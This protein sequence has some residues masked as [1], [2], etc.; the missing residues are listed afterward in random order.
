VSTQVFG[1]LTPL[2]SVDGLKGR[3]KVLCRCS[4]GNEKS[5]YVHNLRGGRTQSC[6][7]LQLE[8]VTSHGESYTRLYRC[9]EHMI[10]RCYVEKD[11]AYVYYGGRGIRVCEEWRLDYVSFRNWAIKNGYEGHLTIDRIDNDGC[12]C[13]ENCRWAPQSEQVRNRRKDTKASSRYKGVS[14]DKQ[15]RKWR[16]QIQI[17]GKNIYLGRFETEED[18]S[19]AYQIALKKCNS[20]F[21]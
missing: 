12:Y 13:P 16:S 5:I 20:I 17:D 10:R 9:W 18:A 7:C 1:R 11:A 21:G 2:R 14:W 6:G 4:C 8:R 3:S 19:E 15:T